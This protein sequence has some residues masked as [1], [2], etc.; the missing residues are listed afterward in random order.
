MVGMGR[1]ERGLSV[2]GF[3][4]GSVTVGIGADCTCWADFT[5]RFSPN[6]RPKF[7]V[8][9]VAGVA[10]TRGGREE[11]IEV[12]RDERR[13]YEKKVIVVWILDL[14]L[15]LAPFAER[16]LVIEWWVFTSKDLSATT[17]STS[18]HIMM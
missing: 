7:V 2:G 18:H 15:D 14:L 8:Y 9:N 11:M 1:G 4:T 13:Q 17:K 3:M 12:V 16:E 10:T 5:P 6:R